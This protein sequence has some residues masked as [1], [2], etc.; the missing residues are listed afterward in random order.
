[1]G[2]MTLLYTADVVVVKRFFPPA[3]AGYYGG[4]STVANIVF[5][6][7]TPIIGVMVPL[8]KRQQAAS[9]NRRAF[10]KCAVMLLGV[11]GPVCLAFTLA[12]S[13]FVRWLMGAKYLPYAP[14]LPYQ[15]WAFFFVALAHAVT[16]YGLALRRYALT[17]AAACDI[18]LLFLLAAF[19]HGSL[20]QVVQN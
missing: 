2:A 8:V 13:V 15:A 6:C 5:F 17:A 16:M 1:M 18:V 7:A 11:V 9:L 4:V 12:P 14:L 10:R 19:R 20:D 3:I